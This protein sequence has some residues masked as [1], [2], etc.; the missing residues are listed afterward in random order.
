MLAVLCLV[1]YLAACLASAQHMQ[2]APPQVITKISPD[3][4]SC[5]LGNRVTLLI[6]TALIPASQKPEV[7][8]TVL[9]TVCV[10]VYVC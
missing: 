6:I 5:P 1:G 7:T 8:P 10:C 4:A 2:V 3:L 9:S